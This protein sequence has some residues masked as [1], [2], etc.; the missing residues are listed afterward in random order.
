M[1]AARRRTGLVW[2]STVGLGGVA[3]YALADSTAEWLIWWA[4]AAVAYTLVT[5]VTRLADRVLR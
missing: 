4:L 2:A 5:L 3:L 1:S